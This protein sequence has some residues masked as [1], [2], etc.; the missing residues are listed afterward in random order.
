[1]TSSVILIRNNFFSLFT[2]YFPV[3][4]T[5]TPESEEAQLKRMIGLAANPVQGLASTYDYSKGD[6]K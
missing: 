5:F 2:V 3:P 1:M 4:E 6:W